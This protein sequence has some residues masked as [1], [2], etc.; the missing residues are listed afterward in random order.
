[1]VYGDAMVHGN[2]RIKGDAKVENIRDYI[3]FKNWWSSGR[4]LTWTRS[5]NKW[6]VGCFYG[7]GE[8]LVEKAYKDSELSGIEYK[9]LVDYVESIQQNE[10]GGEKGA[11]QHPKNVWHSS[12]EE[13]L[14]KSQQI[15]IYSDDFEY[16]FTDFPNYLIVKDGGQNKTWETAVLRNKI[17]KWAYVKD[18]LPKGKEQ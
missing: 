18:I 15:L 16:F 7:T 6:S 10:K 11:D 9:R 17:S 4:H 3:I 2:A 1:M 12:E 8:E 5:N 14:Y 13:P